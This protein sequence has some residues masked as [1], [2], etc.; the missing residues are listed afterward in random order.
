MA[1]DRFIVSAAMALHE[2][3]QA[4]NDPELEALGYEVRR[5][6]PLFLAGGRVR[7]IRMARSSVPERSV[8][9]A[10][11]LC[12]NRDPLVW[13]D[14]QA[15]RPER[16]YDDVTNHFNLT[17]AINSRGTPVPASG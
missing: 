2:Q 16:F 11:Y 5:L 17:D 12:T 14:P 4:G 3:P 7:G 9:G 1:I 15:F 13:K 6:C 10:R 8:A